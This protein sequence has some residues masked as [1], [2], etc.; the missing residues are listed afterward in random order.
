MIGEKQ[1]YE[2]IK[3]YLD[4]YDSKRPHQEFHQ[5]IPSGYAPQRSGGIHRVPI[6]GGLCYHYQR[7]AA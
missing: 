3:T 5:N 1:I 2:I 7:K 4:Y 6:L